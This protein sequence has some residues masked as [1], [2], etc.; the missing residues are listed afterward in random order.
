MARYAITRGRSG[1]AVPSQRRHVGAQLLRSGT[2]S[3]ANYEEACAAESR[4]D[5]IHKLK[6]A[7]KELRES[8]FWLRLMLKAELRTTPGIQEV[9]QEASELCNIV[10]KS[11][12]TAKTNAA[13]KSSA[14]RVSHLDAR[15]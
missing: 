6:I 13:K 5:C 7:L 15:E 3:A 14:V 9:A 1:Y 10:A 12:V 11:I 2:S 8:R 4:A